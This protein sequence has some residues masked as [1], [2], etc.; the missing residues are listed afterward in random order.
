MNGTAACDAVFIV[1]SPWFR[2]RN[3]VPRAP[4]CGVTTKAKTNKSPFRYSDGPRCGRR[5][6]NVEK[7]HKGF[8]TSLRTFIRRLIVVATKVLEFSKR[9]LSL[10]DFAKG[11]SCKLYEYSG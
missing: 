4:L 3:A 6:A 8:M 10:S 9:G 11:Q 5:A 2:H 1:S 7:E